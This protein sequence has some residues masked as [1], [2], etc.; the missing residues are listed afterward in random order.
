MIG[1]RVI[2]PKIGRLMNPSYSRFEVYLHEKMQNK[3]FQKANYLYFFILAHSQGLRQS[4][5]GDPNE[6]GPHA[7]TVSL[8]TRITLK[9]T[10]LEFFVSTL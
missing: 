7:R 5:Q 9:K 10:L 4:G 1:L 3:M 8:H 6:N 2:E